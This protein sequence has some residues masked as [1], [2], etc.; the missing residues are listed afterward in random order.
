MSRAKGRAIAAVLALTTF[1]LGFVLANAQ[2]YG[3]D[4][5]AKTTLV[6]VNGAIAVLVNY[7]PN[8]WRPDP[9]TT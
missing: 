5:V 4:D 8:I 1:G 7:L 3:L 2:V 9:A 6:G